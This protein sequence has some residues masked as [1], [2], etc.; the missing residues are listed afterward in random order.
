MYTSKMQDEGPATF[1]A[2][3]QERM[4]IANEWVERELHDTNESVLYTPRKHWTRRT[5]SPS[6][7]IGIFATTWYP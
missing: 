5:Q 6:L 2:R 1:I 3:L 7:A 4:K